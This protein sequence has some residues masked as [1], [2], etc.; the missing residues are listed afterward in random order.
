MGS[1]L[2]TVVANYVH[3][4]D[5][6]INLRIYD[7]DTALQL[8]WN[9]AALRRAGTTSVVVFVEEH[10]LRVLAVHLAKSWHK[11]H[12]SDIAGNC[13]DQS[14]SHQ[15]HH[16]T[17]HHTT[18]HHTTPHHTTPHHTTCLRKSDVG[19]CYWQFHEDYHDPINGSFLYCWLHT[20]SSAFSILNLRTCVANWNCAIGLIL[21]PYDL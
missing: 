9:E 1:D 20:T 6:S 14:V 18:P 21:T 17:P 2:V 13:M 19:I 8:E 7:S 10:S 12:L 11:Y 15:W 3:R 5:Q 4:H 16:T